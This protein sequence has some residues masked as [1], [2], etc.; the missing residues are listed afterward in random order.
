[1]PG[2]KKIQVL[3]A[4][5]SGVL[6]SLRILGFTRSLRLRW[7]SS[8]RPVLRTYRRKAQFMCRNAETK[9]MARH[10]GEGSSEGRALSHPG[11]MPATDM[12]L[13]LPEALLGQ[14]LLPSRL[15]SLIAW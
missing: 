10:R 14:I 4:V 13:V 9:D 7:L 2:L 1:M 11:S 15:C 3:D 6:S 5:N 12:C 8:W